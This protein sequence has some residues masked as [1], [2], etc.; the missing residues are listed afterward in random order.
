MMRL[1]HTTI[2][3]YYICMTQFLVAF[4]SAAILFAIIEITWITQVARPYIFHKIEP[5]IEINLSAALVFY[6]VYASGIL[7]FAV[8]PALASGQWK[9]ALFMGCLF[10]FFCYAT[11]DL[12][13]MATL[14][15]WEW[16]MVVLD[17][18]WGTAL[19]GFVA[20]ASYWITKFVVG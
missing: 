15:D 19:T 7:F 4:F 14:R 9:T 1:Y 3:W 6:I 12:T 17:V 20:T 8:Y 16:S 13:N 2:F 10:G 18:L 11:Y 5:L